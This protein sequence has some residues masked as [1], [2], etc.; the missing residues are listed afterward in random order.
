MFAMRA[1]NGHKTHRGVDQEYEYEYHRGL[2]V[3]ATQTV[4]LH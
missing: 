4:P 1:L 3:L 2:L